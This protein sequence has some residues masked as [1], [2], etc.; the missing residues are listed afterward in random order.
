MNLNKK[1][2]R[3][4]LAFRIMAFFLAFLMV[5]GAIAGIIMYL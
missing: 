4:Q 5:A 2:K 1:R 3:A